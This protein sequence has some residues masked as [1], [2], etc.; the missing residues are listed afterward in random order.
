MGRRNMCGL[1]WFKRPALFCQF[2]KVWIL[3]K[4]LVCRSKFIVR[5]HSK[6]YVLILIGYCKTFNASLISAK[7]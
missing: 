5:I 2:E 4:I 1:L 6:I 7:H 3:I